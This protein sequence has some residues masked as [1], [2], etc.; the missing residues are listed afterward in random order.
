VKDDQ[1][2]EVIRAVKVNGIF[3]DKLARICENKNAKLLQIATDCVYSG[4]GGA[5]TESAKHDA[6]DVYGKTKSLGETYRKSAHHIRCSIIGPEFR[7]GTFLLSWFLSIPQNGSCNGFTNHYWNGVTTLA[8]AN[9]LR[10]IMLFETELPHLLHLTPS[11]PVTKFELLESFQRHYNRPDI[12]INPTEA[13]DQIDRTLS[14]SHPEM[15]TMLWRHAGYG[16]LPPSVDD[17]V[18]EMSLF[19]YG[20]KGHK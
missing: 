17:L 19:D 11:E 3:P 12:K 1:A 8:F 13:L 9:I 20:F 4:N 5:Y 7:R 6:L 15:N 16:M 14:S 2:D 10:G 18:R